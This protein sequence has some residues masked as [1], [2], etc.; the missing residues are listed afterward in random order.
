MQ[1]L[2]VM[3][4]NDYRP[5]IDNYNALILGLCKSRR[6]DISLDVFM[7]MIEKGFMPN[8]ATY[9]ILVEGIAHEEELEL[10]SETLKEL[11]TKHVVSRK[12]VERLAVQYDLD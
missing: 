6:T 10:A 11:F 8:E 4:E 12:T 7:T 9:T 1:I 5:D 2:T 3:E